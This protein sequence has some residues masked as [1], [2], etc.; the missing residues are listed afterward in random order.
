MKKLAFLLGLILLLCGGCKYFKKSTPVSAELIT[1]DTASAEE[2]FDSSAYYGAANESATPDMPVQTYTQNAV[3]GKYYMIVGCFTV[4]T[5]ADRYAE[6]I[7]G[8]G[9]EAQIIAGVNNFQMVAARSY[10][11]YRLSVSDLDK[12]RNEVTPN[13]WIHKQR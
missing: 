12:F 9:Y 5:N 13:A 6:K 8:M 7:R 3:T 2:T 4:S 10:D 11:N 1:A